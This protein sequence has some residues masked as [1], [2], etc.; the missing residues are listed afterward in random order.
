[1][2][3]LTSSTAAARASASSSTVTLDL[4]L[5]AAGE[6]SGH[7]GHR[8][9]AVGLLAVSD[10]GDGGGELA[11]GG[12]KRASRTHVQTLRV[13]ERNLLGNHVELLVLFGSCRA[14]SAN[15]SSCA[16]EMP[17]HA[18]ATEIT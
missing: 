17:P 2:P 12:G 8:R 15:H 14:P 16:L 7:E 3:L 1:M 13:D 18:R 5:S 9:L 11:H 6:A 10:D 4:D